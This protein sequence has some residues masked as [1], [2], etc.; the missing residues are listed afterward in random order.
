MQIFASMEKQNFLE[1]RSC[2]PS[3]AASMANPASM[4]DAPKLKYLID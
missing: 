1:D 3:R 2:F 4:G